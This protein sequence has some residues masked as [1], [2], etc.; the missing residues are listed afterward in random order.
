MA[1]TINTNVPSLQ[2]QRK[3]NQTDNTMKDRFAR[4]ASGVR[5]NSAKDD[6][7][8]L[9]VSDQMMSQIRGLNQSSRNANDGISLLQVAEGGLQGISDAMQRM[10]ELAVQSANGSLND[11]D[12]AAIQTEMDQLKSE[13]NRI[14]EQTQFNGQPLLDGSYTNKN[15]QTGPSAGQGVTVDIPDASGATLGTDG[16]SVASQATAE[17]ALSTLDGSLSK[18]ADM[19]S[20]LGAMQNRFT[21]VI[22][23][24]G[25]MA[26]NM[27][28]AHS[29]ITDA[30]I[31]EES[32][33][34]T[35]SSILSRAGVAMSAQANQQPQLALQLLA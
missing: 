7:A 35:Q 11:N 23:D 22:A 24:L 21:S 32:A 8:G 26:E 13:V 9:A 2:N 34:L 17:S 14:S 30:D 27:L 6:A 1:M 5:I 10:R 31:A 29:R 18:L 20:S 16:V 25:S 3:L 33:M 28:S 15:I 19:R 4:I 12:R